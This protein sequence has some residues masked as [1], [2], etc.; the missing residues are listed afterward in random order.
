MQ[1]GSGSWRAGWIIV[2]LLAAVPA[3]A[4]EIGVRGQLA[5]PDGRDLT[6]VHGVVLAGGTGRSGPRLWLEAQVGSETQS[7]P[8]LCPLPPTSEVCVGGTEPT[9]LDVRLIGFSLGWVVRMLAQD[10]WTL[11]AV[12][13]LGGVNVRSERFGQ[14]TGETLTEKKTLPRVG[15]AL[16]LGRRIA[17]TVPIRVVVAG[18]ATRSFSFTGEDCTGCYLTSF[19]NGFTAV[20][21]ELQV[22]YLFH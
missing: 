21:A 12:P 14:E 16:E 5:W 4:Q 9:D 11:D 18:R 15:F 3:C 10:E 6:A 19:R 13:E 1:K 7:S 2:A 22:S 8:A 20:G 17:P